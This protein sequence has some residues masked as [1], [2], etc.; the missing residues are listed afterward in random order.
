MATWNELIAMRE[1]GLKPSL[2]VVI[3]TDGKPPANLLRDSGY[4]VIRHNPGEVFHGEQL[5][6]LDV[7]L[8]LGNCDRSAAV[9][10]TL[11]NLGVKPKSLTAWC[12]CA[13]RL[14]HQPVRCEVA[15]EWH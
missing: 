12:E 14:D 8:F 11:R 10:R 5:D 2:H 7:L 9:V 6:G 13:K 4:L 15:Q 3:T 1:R